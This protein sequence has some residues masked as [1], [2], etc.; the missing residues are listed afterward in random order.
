MLP[1]L[2]FLLTLGLVE[3]LGLDRPIANAWSFDAATGRWLGSGPGDWWAHR[4]LHDDGRWLVRGIAALAIGVWLAS[5]RW[6]RWRA[7]RASAGFIG[8]GMIVAIGIVGALKAV[9]NVDCP[10]DLAGFGGHN[11][12]VPLLAHRPAYL[13]RARCFP[14]A[15]SAS[16]FALFSLYFAFRDAAP[17]KARLGLAAGLFLGCLFAFGQE[18]RG[19]HFFSHD[20]AG[21]GAVWFV[22]L[23]LYAWLLAPKP[24]ASA[25]TSSPRPPAY[26]TESGWR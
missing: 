15:H 13:P 22:Q 10:W 6:G 25:A 2:G 14:G 23:A 3:I 26:E 9:T 20:L 7:A 19:A 16:G 11:P 24:A 8:L 4:L 1:L 12:Y 5:F 17:A 21:A 18:A